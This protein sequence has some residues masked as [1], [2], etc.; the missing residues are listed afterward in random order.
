MALT[1]RCICDKPDVE[2]VDRDW[3]EVAVPRLEVRSVSSFGGIEC[4][5]VWNEI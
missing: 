1:R 3:R 4:S 2:V 5:S